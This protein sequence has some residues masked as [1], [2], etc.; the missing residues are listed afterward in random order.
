[1][2]MDMNNGIIEGVCVILGDEP[3]HYKP[4]RSNPDPPISPKE[5]AAES[6]P[7]AEKSLFDS[8][9]FWFFALLVVGIRILFPAYAI[10]AVLA[11]VGFLVLWAIQEF[12][13]D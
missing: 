4:Q 10:S 12:I 3:S 7:K 6:S 1:M 5:Q 2:S 13:N 9:W 11:G 8:G